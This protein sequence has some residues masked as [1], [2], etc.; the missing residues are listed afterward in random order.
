MNTKNILIVEGNMDMVSRIFLDLGIDRAHNVWFAH[1]E[2]DACAKLARGGYHLI[3]F[4]GT[5]RRPTQDAYPDP[6]N[7]KH[8]LHDLLTR[9]LG[10]QENS[11]IL[12]TDSDDLRKMMEGKIF[13]SIASNNANKL[14]GAIA[15]ILNR[16]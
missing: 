12:L 3:L 8:Q 11:T 6:K 10:G 2:S 7:K 15:K 4:L 16:P 13:A 9:H 1:T 5:I 14:A